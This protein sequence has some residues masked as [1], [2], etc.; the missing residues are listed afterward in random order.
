MHFRAGILSS[1]EV[2]NPG[3]GSIILK[4]HIGDL[5]LRDLL[6]ILDGAQDKEQI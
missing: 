2:G 6:V 1:Q 4:D 3:D 5:L